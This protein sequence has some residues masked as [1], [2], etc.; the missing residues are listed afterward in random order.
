M[1]ELRSVGGTYRN[2]KSELRSVGGTY[3]KI[4]KSYRSVSGVYRQYFG[5]CP[6]G[7]AVIRL[8]QSTGDNTL[9]FYDDGY[10]HGSA[11]DTCTA[12][13]ILDLYDTSGNMISYNTLEDIAGLDTFELSVN[14]VFMLFSSGAATASDN[15]FGINAGTYEEWSS[16]VARAEGDFAVTQDDFTTKYIEVAW[17]GSCQRTV[18]FNYLLINGEEVPLT[19]TAE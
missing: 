5:G 8:Y 3:R 19:I 12:K 13:L 16:Y 1:K 14:T 6:I 7:A 2:I 11:D 10:S 18:T 9:T 15:I 17:K 4:A